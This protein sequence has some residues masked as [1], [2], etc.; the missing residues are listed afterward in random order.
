MSSERRK[1][2]I[3]FNFSPQWMGGIIYI[4]NIVKT[5][6]F[7]EEDEKP[8]VYLFY[9]RNLKKFLDEFNYPHLSKIEYPFPSIINGNIKSFLLRKNLFFDRILKE[10]AMDAI[11]PL[12]DFPVKTN[13]GVKL[14]SWWA[15]LQEKY[16]PE[17][18]S[19]GT[20]LARDIRIR[21]ILRNCNHLVVSSQ[22]VV[23]D[24]DRFYQPK[25]SIK[26]KIYHFVSVIDESFNEDIEELKKKYKLPDEYFLVSN[27]FHKHKN[28][29][30]ILLALV[31]LN[32]MGLRKHVAF[33][34]KLPSGEDS[35]YLSELHNII[36]EFKLHDQITM[37]GVI[38]RN[39]Q[40]QLMRYSQAVLQPSL[41]EGWSTVIEDAKSLQAPAVASNIKVNIEQLGK[42]GVYFDPHNPDELASIIAHFPVRNLKDVFYEDYSMRIKKAAKELLDILSS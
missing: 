11:F 39:D 6:N 9:N 32:Q 36:D 23:D 14:I 34:G 29:K 26:I 25:E 24:F 28:H 1:I 35:P 5:L 40:L 20:I 3:I 42:D 22:S 19:S 41:F 2:G 4:I 16:Y 38:S 15:D 31:K 8:D 30:I 27:Q 33:T 10:Y 17:F 21:L 37:L 7:L 18:F 13:T 12:P